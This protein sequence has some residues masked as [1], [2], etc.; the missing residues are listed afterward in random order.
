MTVGSLFDLAQL[1]G[2]P[3]IP[4]LRRFIDA[5]PDF[6]VIEH[7]QYGRPFKLE[8]EAAA[9]FVREHWRDGR[10]LSLDDDRLAQMDFIEEGLA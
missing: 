6:P 2:M 5:R 8:L 10:R 7:G 1:D 9:S 4:S 3:S